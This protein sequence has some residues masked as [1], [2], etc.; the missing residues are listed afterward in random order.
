MFRVWE[1]WDV[2]E[3]DWIGYCEERSELSISYGIKIYKPITR[4]GRG[5]SS[6]NVEV[7][8]FNNEVCPG[9]CKG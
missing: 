7:M 5:V 3:G 4:S 9:K 8:E 2:G 1:V 6:W